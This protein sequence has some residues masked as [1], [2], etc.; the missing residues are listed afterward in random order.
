MAID[1]NQQAAPA[2]DRLFVAAAHELELT[3]WPGTNETVLDGT[4]QMRLRVLWASA[5]GTAANGIWQADPVRLRLLHPFDETFVVLS[6]R[7]TVAP[8]GSEP[9]TM[10]PGDVIT[11]PE[12]VSCEWTIHETVT[13]LFAIYRKEGLPQ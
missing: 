8:D 3:P 12:G 2:V 9:Q 11:L 7:M 1:Q 5:D 4:L 10:G 13:K 6:G